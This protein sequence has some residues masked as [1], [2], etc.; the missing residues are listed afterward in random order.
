MR[1]LQGVLIRDTYKRYEAGMKL[2]EGVQGEYKIP[3]RGMR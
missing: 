3:T 1:L 2:L